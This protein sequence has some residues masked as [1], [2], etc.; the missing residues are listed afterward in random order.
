[1]A[2]PFPSEEVAL[3]STIPASW[4]RSPNMYELE[5]RAIYSR[6]WILI[7]HESQFTEVG[8]YVRYEMAGYPFVVVRNRQGEINAFLNV[9]RHRAF[10]I[11]HQDEGKANIFSCK[12]H[13]WFELFLSN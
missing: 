11:V 3:S 7:S 9:C 5:R 1:M 8:K 4:F 12:Y 10:P 2:L 13:G 6:T